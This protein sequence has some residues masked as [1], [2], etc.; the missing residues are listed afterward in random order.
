MAGGTA[1][2]FTLDIVAPTAVPEPATLIP[3][4]VGFALLGLGYTWRRRATA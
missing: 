4:L 1:D 2:S 3:A